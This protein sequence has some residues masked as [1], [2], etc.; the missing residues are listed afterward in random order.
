MLSRPAFNALL[1]TLEEPPSHVIFILA[2][3]ELHKVPET[4]VSRCQALSFTKPTPEILKKV[5]KEV[6]KKEGYTLD[7]AGAHLVSLLGEG[8]FRDTLGLL[9]KV[10]VSSSDKKLN[11]AEVER[12]TGAPKR[13]VVKDF[14]RALLSEDRKEALILIQVL[15]HSGADMKT[16]LKLILEELRRGMLAA[17]A[18]E[19]LG[20]TYLAVDPAEQA[21]YVELAASP[22]AH[23]LPAILKEFLVA[24][25][26]LGTAYLPA[27][28]LE[29]AVAN[30]S[31]QLQDKKDQTR[32]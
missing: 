16:L 21:F 11:L 6:S 29:L 14:V 4:V 8:S 5:I 3:T 9:Q 2:T 25:D 12:I 18:P 7:E 30:I 20:P 28:P 19:L 27:L 17:Y 22:N 32:I 15:A 10:M 13:E 1:K 31:R 23:F 26:E 24:Y